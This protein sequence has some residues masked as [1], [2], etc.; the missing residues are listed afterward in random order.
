MYINFLYEYKHLNTLY[1]YDTPEERN[2]AKTKPRGKY[3]AVS[4][5]KEFVEKVRKHILSHKDKANYRSI[6]EFTKQ[7][8]IEKIDYDR[9]ER[10]RKAFGSPGKDS[11]EISV[12]MRKVIDLQ[13]QNLDLQQRIINLQNKNKNNNKGHGLD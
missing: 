4:L 5:P 9:T 10:T 2:M 8:V 11:K 12:L 3:Q 6:A 1:A 7:A 13:Q